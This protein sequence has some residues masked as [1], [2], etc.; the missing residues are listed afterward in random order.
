[1]CSPTHAPNLDVNGDGK[2]GLEEVL[3]LLQELAD[4]R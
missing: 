4:L 3:Y 1:V 2:I